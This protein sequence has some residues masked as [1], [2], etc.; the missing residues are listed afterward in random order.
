MRSQRTRGGPLAGGRSEAL[1][2]DPPYRIQP[3]F[4]MSLTMVESMGDVQCSS[5]VSSM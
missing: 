5:I 1:L 3:C 4:L 2:D